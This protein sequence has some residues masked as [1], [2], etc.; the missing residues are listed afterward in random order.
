MGLPVRLAIL[1]FVYSAHLERTTS[2]F[3]VFYPDNEPGKSR[4][5][6]RTRN[7]TLEIVALCI[8]C[9]V[10][11]TEQATAIYL[12]IQ[13]YNANPVSVIVSTV[14]LFCFL[15]LYIAFY[16]SPSIEKTPARKMTVISLIL[17][18]VGT[19]LLFHIKP[20]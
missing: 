9:L 17:L 8:T 12:L 19:V 13:T 4:I 3:E 1:K 16:F 18:L 6:S 14:I 7:A 11:S 15:I 5:K 10:F 2:F 20:K